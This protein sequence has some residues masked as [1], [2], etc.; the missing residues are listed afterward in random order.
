MTEPRPTRGGMQK[1]LKPSNYSSAYLKPYWDGLLQGKFLLPR[2]AKCRE[3]FFPP[4]PMCPKCL[5]G[6]LAW[7]EMEP[8]GTLHSWSELLDR[9]FLILEVPMVLG[10]VDLKNSAGRLVTRIRAPATEVKIGMPLRLVFPKYTHEGKEMA[11][12]EAEPVR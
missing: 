2:C 7:E 10:V 4:R 1:F 9:R 3:L 11:M 6:E 12:V 8:E 5:S